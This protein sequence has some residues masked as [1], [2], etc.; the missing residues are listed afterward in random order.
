MKALKQITLTAIM[1]LFTTNISMAGSFR[2]FQMHLTDGR[3]IEVV[4][5]VEKV[6]KENI[7]TYKRLVDSKTIAHKSTTS[8]S[9]NCEKS[10][11]ERVLRELI[12]QIQKPESPVL[13][14]D[15]NT[16]AIFKQYLQEKSYRLTVEELS[17]LVKV[18]KENTEV[19]PQP[20]GM[21]IAK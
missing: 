19:H 5:R 2:K 16:Q 3:T 21:G 7:P 4:S 13:E 15:L 12:S 11:S 17:N 8:E 14:K 20:L 9:W 10:N 18:E 6:V 1:I